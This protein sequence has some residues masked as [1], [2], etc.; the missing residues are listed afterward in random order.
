MS[1]ILRETFASMGR[2]KLSLFFSVFSFTIGVLL[3][4]F[5]LLTL[6]FSEIVKGNVQ[7]QF[8]MSLFL[9]DAVTESGVSDLKAVLSKKQYVKTLSYISKEEA[10]SSF[11]RETGEDF[12]EILDYNPLPASFVVSFHEAYLEN[13]KIEAIKNELKNV[14]G[15][16]DVRY[17]SNL[18][19]RLLAIIQSVQLYIWIITGLLGL[20]AIY[21]V[22]ATLR[23]IIH[24][25]HKEIET[26]KL[27]GAS[28]FTIKTPIII[29]GVLIGII[30]NI[31]S[32]VL[33]LGIYVAGVKFLGLPR[34]AFSYDN[35][36]LL[37]SL[38]IGP[39]IGLG[40]SFLATR[41]ITMKV[42]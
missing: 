30:A 29:S 8:T 13:S 23:L 11:I 18:I 5:A 10:A 20:V 34:I 9:N 4:Q 12:R 40:C 32:T 39:V 14:S 41:K 35:Y 7:Q 42:A 2:A 25:R 26:M 3:I 16:D 6:V 19:D 17:K 31:I 22:Y 24:N 15:V 37:T 33:L 21:I 27:V 1:F 28:I 36:I 38:F